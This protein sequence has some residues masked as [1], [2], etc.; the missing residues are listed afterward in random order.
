MHSAR[1]VEQGEKVEGPVQADAI[2][3]ANGSSPPPLTRLASA[4]AAARVVQE[5]GPSNEWASHP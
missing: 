2:P 1:S 4:K 3:Q 5:V